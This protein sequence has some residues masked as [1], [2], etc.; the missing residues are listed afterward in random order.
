MGR[1]GWNKRCHG[2]L[3][4]SNFSIFQLDY[5]WLKIVLKEKFK[6]DISFRLSSSYI[7]LPCAWMEH[8][9]L[10]TPYYSSNCLLCFTAFESFGDFIFHTGGLG[11]VL[12]LRN[13]AVHSKSSKV[14]HNPKLNPYQFQEADT[15][16][17]YL[18]RL[19][20]SKRLPK[21]LQFWITSFHKLISK[22]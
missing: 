16:A 22:N 19:Y 9:M 11:R 8:F 10:T 13:P 15:Q 7:S 21:V 14:D 4:N 5:F 12:L 2:P 17:D 6:I 20:S 1:I 18:P 3:L